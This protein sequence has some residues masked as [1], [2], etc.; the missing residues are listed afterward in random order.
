MKKS[1]FIVTIISLFSLAVMPVAAADVST[2]FTR[3]EG[4]GTAPI[5]KAKWE[6]NPGTAGTDDDPAAGAQ[7]TPSGQYQVNKSITIC[8]VVTDPDGMADIN[9]VYADVYYPVGIALG[10]SHV[11]LPDQSGL[12]C[13]Q[14]MQEDQMKKLEKTAGID[15]FCKNI[16]TNNYDLP[17]FNTGY[18]YEEICKAD[19]ELMKETAYVF[20]ATKDLSYEDPSGAYKVTVMA[21]DNA[22]VDGML[23][24]QFEYLDLTAFE[25]DFTAVSYG[26][27][28]LDT[29]KK[30]PG[31]L[32]WDPANSLFPTVRN[33]GNTRLKMQVRQDDMGLG[34]TD[35]LYNVKYD[36]RVGSNAPFAI[37][38]PYATTTL[39]DALDLSELDEMD[40]S[41]WVKKFP[42][43][44]DGNSYTGKMT[45]TA[46]WDPHLCCEATNT[47]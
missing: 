26:N 44:H 21:Q 7:F 30:I 5:V 17:T 38:S 20:C 27:V 41:I 12:G 43:G 8:A 2:G 35:G 34:M 46:V 11:A 28:K 25:T 10:D 39:E 23:D 32:T 47:D 33:V 24:N 6:M 9:G 15:L 29:P 3:D 19:G 22:G 18:D 16:R 4:S 42:P 14:F 37:Y 13:G 36:A 45:L 31:D 1:I 40:F